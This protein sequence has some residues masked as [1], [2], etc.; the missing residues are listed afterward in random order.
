MKVG[1]KFYMDKK[2]AGN[3]ESKGCWRSN[4]KA[5]TIKDK[6]KRCDLIFIPNMLN[7]FGWE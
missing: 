4:R 7:Y 5:Y 6:G 1:D 2:E 3:D